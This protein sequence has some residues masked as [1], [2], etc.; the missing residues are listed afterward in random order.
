MCPTY[1]HEVLVVPGVQLRQG[2]AVEQQAVGHL[3]DELQGHMALEAR[4]HGRE[5]GVAVAVETVLVLLA[6]WALELRW[7]LAPLGGGGGG[8]LFFQN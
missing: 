4:H 2:A 7:A 1:G 3:G 8:E 6:L 5:P